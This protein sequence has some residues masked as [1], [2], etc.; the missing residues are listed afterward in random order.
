M[1]HTVAIQVVPSD[2]L[3]FRIYWPGIHDFFSLPDGEKL[4]S[5]GA[6]KQFPG[7]N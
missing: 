5:D 1:R 4:Q 2:V 7:C 3:V 6:L